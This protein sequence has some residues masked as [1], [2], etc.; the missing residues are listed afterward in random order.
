MW[1]SLVTLKQRVPQPAPLPSIC[2]ALFAKVAQGTEV[3][4][5]FVSMAVVNLEE[6]RNFIV[7]FS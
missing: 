7:S 2:S 3:L 6:G 5:N 4:T 1:L